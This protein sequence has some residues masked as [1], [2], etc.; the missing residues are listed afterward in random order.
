MC[1]SYNFRVSQLY[2]DYYDAGHSKKNQ[3]FTAYAPYWLAVQL[4]TSDWLS[5]TT[6]IGQIQDR[7][8]CA[9]NKM[10]GYVGLQTAPFPQYIA[11]S[12]KN[13]CIFAIFQNF[14]TKSGTPVPQNISYN[15]SKFGVYSSNDVEIMTFFVCAFTKCSNMAVTEFW[16]IL[17]YYKKI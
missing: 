7:T 9:Q 1:K 12:D 6:L 3:P 13:R 16:T 14:C 2:K 15:W 4:L 11:S 10:F 8:Q 17:A 5:Q